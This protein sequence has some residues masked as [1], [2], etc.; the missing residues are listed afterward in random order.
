MFQPAFDTVEAGHALNRVH[1]QHVAPGVLLTRVSG[2]LDR[3]AVQ[4]LMDAFDRVA[5]AHAPV[6]SFHDW[7]D[8][9]GYDDDARQVYVEWSRSH[10][11]SVLTVHILVR[12]PLVAL[13]IAVANMALGGYLRGYGDREEFEMLLQ[14]AIARS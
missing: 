11:E 14:R 8:V 10:P 2:H 3:A 9:T 1:V 12:N 13:A 7:D 5:E 6:E 4:I